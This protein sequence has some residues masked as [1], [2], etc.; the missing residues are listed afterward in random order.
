MKNSNYSARVTLFPLYAEVEV[1][2]GAG[3]MHK[4]V[5][6]TTV[7]SVFSN[8][9]VGTGALPRNTLF[10]DRSGGG[11]RIGVYVPPAMH[12]L[13]TPSMSYYLPM[14]GFVFVGNG[15]SYSLFAVKGDEWPNERT[16]LYYPP[17]PNVYPGGGVCAGEMTFPNCEKK[18]IWR[19]WD[20]VATSYFTG[21]LL[22]GRSASHEKSV[23]DLWHEL[24]LGETAVFPE[25]ELVEA[26]KRLQDV[27]R[28]NA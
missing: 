5:E 8:V 12:K 16:I 25:D 28:G 19:A 17:L 1:N 23:F 22:N 4:R 3:K 15:R 27:I 7:A 11:M 9:P 13:L 24:H 26:G 14:P 21:H 20:M 6:L 18:T 2:D 10:I